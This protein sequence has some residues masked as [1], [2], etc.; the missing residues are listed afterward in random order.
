[1]I[2]LDG[3]SKIIAQ[4][5]GEA[6]IRES[7]KINFVPL[8]N[9]VFTQAGNLQAKLVC[10]IPIVCHRTNRKATIED[11]DFILRRVLARLSLMNYFQI[12]IPLE[13]L[14]KADINKQDFLNRFEELKNEFRNFTFEFI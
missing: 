8:G 2:H 14:K 13:D 3:F 12:L 11:L 7:D 9:F 4:K 10:H 5:A 6:L 1:M